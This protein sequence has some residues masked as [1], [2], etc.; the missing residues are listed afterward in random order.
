MFFGKLFNTFTVFVVW[1]VVAQ[2]LSKIISNAVNDAL[3]T[4]RSVIDESAA[5]I[6]G[7]VG[8]CVYV[9]L[10]LGGLWFLKDT[11]FPKKA[12]ND[13]TSDNTKEEKSTSSNSAPVLTKASEEQSKLK[14]QQKE[15]EPSLVK[16]ENE[17]LASF[18]D[19]GIVIE[20]DENASKLWK[21]LKDLDEQ[22]GY[23]F[24]EDLQKDP[25]QDVEKLFVELKEKFEKQKFQQDHPYD[26]PKANEAFQEA[27]Q[28]SK[29]AR[30]E[31]SKVYELM[32]DKLEPDEILEKIKTKHQ[33][34]N[35]R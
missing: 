7:L 21:E 26:D 18:P 5:F 33:K 8:S 12:D 16:S 17:V 27:I 32:K 31:F 2:P 22:I 29:A 14:S 30:D 6:G 9:F 10:L 25:R 20:Y 3:W 34:N 35:W 24:I 13:T 4:D 1:F 11:W 23:E 28:I 15:I 19:A